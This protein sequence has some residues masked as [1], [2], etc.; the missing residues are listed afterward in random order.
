MAAAKPMPAANPAA[1]SKSTTD[2]DVI[3]VP[4]EEMGLAELA[5]LARKVVE[6][7]P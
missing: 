7:K 5:E 1:A 4:V 6:R 3:E 2:D